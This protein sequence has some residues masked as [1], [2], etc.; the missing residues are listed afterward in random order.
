MRLRFGPVE[1]VQGRLQPSLA[2]GRTN[3]LACAA[4][5]VPIFPTQSS[6]SD[7]A[8]VRACG[9]R[10]ILV[11]AALCSLT[12]A[13]ATRYSYGT[14]TST[15]HAVKTLPAQGKVQR[16]LVKD[17]FQGLI[18]VERLTFAT[19][20]VHEPQL[21]TDGAPVVLVDLGNPISN[22]APPLSARLS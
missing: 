13:V 22:R 7:R 14:L 19:V 3:L 16:L 12:L 11:L 1:R 21:V 18:H 2:G 17:G 6:R 8:L 5:V 9:W 20:F 10:A 15:T 4:Q